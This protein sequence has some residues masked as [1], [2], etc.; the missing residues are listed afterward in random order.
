MKIVTVQKMP[1]RKTGIYQNTQTG[2]YEYWL[3]IDK[4]R[5]L[6]TVK[7]GGCKISVSDALFNH[8]VRHTGQALKSLILNLLNDGGI[9]IN[10]DGIAPVRTALDVDGFMGHNRFRQ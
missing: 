2:E 1:V 8:W 6:E 9:T 4:G 10:I 5:G 7:I 3:A